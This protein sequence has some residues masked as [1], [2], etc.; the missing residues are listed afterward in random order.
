MD[1]CQVMDY[2]YDDLRMYFNPKQIA[3]FIKEGIA[4]HSPKSQNHLLF[5]GLIWTDKGNIDLLA[6]EL[7]KRDCIKDKKQWVGLFDASRE[8]SRVAFNRDFMG[9]LAHLLFYLH[10][11]GYITTKGTKGYFA[12]VEGSL[13]DYSNKLFAKNS[14]KRLSSKINSNP[15]RYAGIISDVKNIVAKTH[16]RTKGL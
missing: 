1:T 14:L 16:L 7:K 12:L 8:P 9:H 13:K 2:N 6:Y 5:K 11:E 3:F 4:S 15:S 10:K